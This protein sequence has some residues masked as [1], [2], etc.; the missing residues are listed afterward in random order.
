L[1]LA[2]AER[3]DLIVCDVQLP[4][5]DGY[6]VASRL[7]TQPALR[8]IPLVA[9]TAMAM[10]GDRE[11]VLA[12]GFDGYIAKPIEPAP[13]IAAIEALLGPGRAGLGRPGH[14]AVGTSNPPKRDG[15]VN[16]ATILV[17]DDLKVNIDV[18]SSALAPVGYHVICASGAG[19]ALDLVRNHEPDLIL[20]DVHMPG[21]GGFEILRNIKEEPRLGRIPFAFLSSTV[22]P[23][24]DRRRALELGAAKF[25]SRPIEPEALVAEIEAM[26]GRG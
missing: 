13:F 8:R 7:K 5:I 25:I 2:A 26:L 22:W 24:A 4:G 15:Q 21:Q 10:V 23:E 20:C 1:R 19:Q 12:A 18:V 9:E 3:P 6:E 16:R 17:I 14:A 11:R